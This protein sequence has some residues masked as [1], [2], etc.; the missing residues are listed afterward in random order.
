MKS[1]FRIGAC[2]SLVLSLSAAPLSTHASHHNDSAASKKDGRI[3]ITDM[4]VF[5]SKD[6]RSTV[7]VMNVGKDAGREGPKT[8]HP[9]AFYDFTVDLD[10]DLREDLR[11][12]LRFKEPA[13]DGSQAW[14][15]ERVAGDNPA[16]AEP[17]P[18]ADAA[19]FGDTVSLRGGGRAWVGL[20]G[21]AFAANAAQYFKLVESAKAGKSDFSVFDKPA[22]YF[23]ENDVISLV[24]EVPNTSFAKAEL[25]VWGAVWAINGGFPTQV[26]R[27]GN[28]L[29]AF[30][31]AH[32]ND[33]AEAMNTSRPVDD[34]KLH[35]QRAAERI[36]MFVKA[37]GTASDAKAYADAAAQAL[38]PIVTRY[39]VGTPAFYGIG[40]SN[41]R[42]LGDD[43][44][45]V[46]MSSV[47]NRTIN[48][49]VRPGGIRDEFPHVPLSRRLEAWSSAR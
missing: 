4:Y 49:G 14:S 47:F 43:A 10:G 17:V 13:A 26:N 2:A 42:A 40:A 5:A 33:D 29:T 25:N 16:K 19:R 46:I 7:M 44:F 18:L 12:R 3:N 23:A 35:R 20:A 41:G 34:V 31:F 11:W 15:V 21:D 48:D 28:V 24:I 6:G 45:D 38:V 27:W 36:A 39:K 9:Q 1:L 22:N 30:L 37:S 8:L 32:N